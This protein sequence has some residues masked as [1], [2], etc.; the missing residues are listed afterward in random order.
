MD[1]MSGA[2][3]LDGRLHAGF[4]ELENVAYASELQRRVGPVLAIG[5]ECVHST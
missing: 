5:G 3:A 2:V 1:T 4:C